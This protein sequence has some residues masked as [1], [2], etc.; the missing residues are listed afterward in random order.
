VAHWHYVRRGELKPIIPNQSRADFVLNGALPYELP[1][2]KR[3]LVQ[4][5]PRFVAMGRRCGPCRRARAGP[6]HQRAPRRRPARR[7]RL[8]TADVGAA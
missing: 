7:R 5:S 1:V 3:H 6:A 8:R 4:H 2:F